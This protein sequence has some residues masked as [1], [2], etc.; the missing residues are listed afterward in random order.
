MC[1]DRF[2]SKVRGQALLY[3]VILLVI[4]G[5]GAILAGIIAFVLVKR[6]KA[7]PQSASVCAHCGFNLP[8]SAKFCPG[9]GQPRE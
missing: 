2:L 7:K 8:P 3:L 5:A 1:F 4:L 9:C 6:A